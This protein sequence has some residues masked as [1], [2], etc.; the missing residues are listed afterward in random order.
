M[1]HVSPFMRRVAQLLPSSGRSSPVL[2]SIHFRSTCLDKGDEILGTGTRVKQVV[3]I[4]HGLAM[5]YRLLPDGSRQVIM[6]LTAG[7]I[8]NPHIYPT[9][10]DHGIAAVTQV[11]IDRFE[12]ESLIGLTNTVVGLNQALWTLAEEQNAI[13]RD[14]ITSLGRSDAKARV[15]MLLKELATRLS[16][17]EGREPSQVFIPVTQTLLADAIGLTHIHFNR[18]IGDMA[19]RGAI[20]TSRGG[21]TINSISTLEKLGAELIVAA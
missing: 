6:F 18:I 2:D 10:M 13:M 7:D 8:C 17:Y 16:S 21:I 20:A 3:T 5:R 12:C 1:H 14:H 15:L 9:V 19:K 4:G 11:R